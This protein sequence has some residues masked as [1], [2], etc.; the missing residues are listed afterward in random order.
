MEKIEEQNARRLVHSA[1]CLRATRFAFEVLLPQGPLDPWSSETKIPLRV[2]TYVLDVNELEFDKH[3]KS[4]QTIHGE[5]KA[6]IHPL[7]RQPLCTRN[8]QPCASMSS[9][10]W[11]DALLHPFVSRSANLL[12]RYPREYPFWRKSLEVCRGGASR[13][14]T[15]RP[16]REKPLSCNL[17]WLCAR[18]TR[19]CVPWS[20]HKTLLIPAR[21]NS[22]WFP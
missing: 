20:M 11:R 5:Q 22:P 16:P 17:L 8:R 13:K 21:R 9:P 19:K 6:N 14:S 2:L 10:L 1:K 3:K 18:R 4:V 15:D 12:A 7:L